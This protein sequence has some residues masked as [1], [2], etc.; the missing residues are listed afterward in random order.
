[1]VKRRDVTRIPVQQVKPGFT[2]AIPSEGGQP[3]RVFQVEEVGWEY[4][5]APGEK[6]KM[7]LTSE[8]LPDSGEPWVLKYPIGTL[9][10]RVMRTYDDGT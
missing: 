3:R 2:L 4:K 10:A 9:V 1:V 7:V 8:P 6:A 5:N